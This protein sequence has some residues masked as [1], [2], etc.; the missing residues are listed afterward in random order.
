ML[1]HKISIDKKGII[2]SIDGVCDGDFSTAAPQPPLDSFRFSINTATMSVAPIQ[3]IFYDFGLD[4]IGFS[5][6][7]NSIRWHRIEH[8]QAHTHTKDKIII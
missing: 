4:G 2:F 5:L 3:N 6:R 8:T 7:Q 1:S